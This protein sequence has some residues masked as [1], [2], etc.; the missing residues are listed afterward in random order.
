[1]GIKIPLMKS[2]FLNEE[3]TKKELCDFIMK[4]EKLSMGEQ[5][6]E[7]ETEFSK[8]Q[9]RK[10]SIMVNSG[11]SAN[12]VLLQSLLNLKYIKPGARIGVSAVTWAT[13]VMPIIQLGCI[14]V[15]V[16]VSRM[17]MNVMSEYLPKDI[18]VLFIT[19]LLGF[20]GDIYRV[21]EFCKVNNIILLEDT[22][23]SLGTTIE[24]DKKLGNYGLAS[25][26]ST[27][28]GH[29]MSTIEGGLISTDDK[30]LNDMLRMVRAHG[31]DRNV[32]ENKRIEL[33]K[34]WKIDDFHGPYTFYTLGYN[35][36]PTEIQGFIGLKQLEHIDFA[37]TKRRETFKTIQKY[38]N[39][40]P[41][42][43]T[44]KMDVPAFAIPV[45]CK[46]KETKQF[47]V[48]KCIENG[49]EVR[50]LVAGS[51]NKQPYFEDYIRT[52]TPNAD[53]LHDCAFYLPNHPDLTDAEVNHLYSIFII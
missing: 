18:D 23:E 29:H 9:G 8:W 51:M 26:F 19:H 17:N 41:G 45:I 24:H 50:P 31:W 32:D 16:E 21:S 6:S 5:V 15:L 43:Y 11:S 4:S 14:P 22:C 30:D 7:F 39:K 10:Y 12:L 48:N 13:N 53:F 27:F 52:E 2:T 1:M 25:T 33:R 36:R 47:Y 49:I 34:E 35:V 37:N 46:N 38:I 3:E 40:I 28:V 20:C 42:L 44:P